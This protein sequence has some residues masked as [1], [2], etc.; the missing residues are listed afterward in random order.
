MVE[1]DTKS[2]FFPITLKLLFEYT[3]QYYELKKEAKVNMRE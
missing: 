1:H 2:N 3:K